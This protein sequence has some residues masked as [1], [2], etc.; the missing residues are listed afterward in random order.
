M[1]F[2]RIGISQKYKE[3]SIFNAKLFIN[4]IKF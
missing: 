4:F 3:L 2:N 1:I